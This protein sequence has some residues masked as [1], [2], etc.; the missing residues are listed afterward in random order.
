MTALTV[1]L[2]HATDACRTAIDRELQTIADGIRQT[3][4][5]ASKIRAKAE[6]LN[7]RARYLLGLHTSGARC[8]L[9]GCE[10]C[11]GEVRHG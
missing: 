4:A 3:R 10:E 9:P 2:P 1:I 11:R 5:E 7:R 8:E 6:R